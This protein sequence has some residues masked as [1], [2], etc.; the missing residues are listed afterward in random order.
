MRA[1]LLV[2]LVVSA[3]IEEKQIVGVEQR[4]H[5]R[6]VFLEGLHGGTVANDLGSTRS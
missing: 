3:L 4:L 6:L 5:A 2:Q 1:E